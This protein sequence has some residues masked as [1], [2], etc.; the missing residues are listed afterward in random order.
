MARIAGLMYLV[1]IVGGL[2]SEAYVRS[3]IIV[4]GDATATANNII[5]SESLF[6]IGF[7]SDLIVFLCDVVVS[8]ILYVL[9][10][11]VNKTLALIA[12]SFRLVMTAISGINL[13]NLFAPLLLLSGA[14]YLSVFNLDQLQALVML[15]LKTHTYG[16]HIALTFFGLHCLIL[17]YLLYKSNYFPRILGVL[18]I[19]AS[20]GYL[21]NSFSNFL[22]NFIRI[23]YMIL[24]L[25]ALIAELS[26]CMWLIIK[27]IKITQIK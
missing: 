12:A 14:D 24:L 25:P 2:F 4:S 20:F 19:I 22:P 3:S 18:M 6:R 15:F 10:K 23:N 17:G 7:A 5:A 11:A 13:L 26:L 9:L 16:Y 27:G 21:I 1:I 8:I